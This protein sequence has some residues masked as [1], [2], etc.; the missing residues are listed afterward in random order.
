MIYQ[1]QNPAIK[2]ETDDSYMNRTENKDPR[3]PGER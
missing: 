1:L 3:E 2:L